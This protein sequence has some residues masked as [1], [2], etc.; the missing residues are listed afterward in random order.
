MLT[1]ICPGKTASQRYALA[2][3]AGLNLSLIHI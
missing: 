3:R 1:L 2:L